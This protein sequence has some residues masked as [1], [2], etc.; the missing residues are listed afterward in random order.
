MNRFILLLLFFSFT[1]FA[2]AKEPAIDA[3]LKDT[4]IIVTAE[5]ASKEDLPPIGI[6]SQ[7]GSLAEY[8]IRFRINKI[9]KSDAALRPGDFIST[10]LSLFT[11]DDFQ[12]VVGKPL[13]L[14]LRKCSSAVDRFENTSR[15]FG[16]MNHNAIRESSLDWSI[17]EAAS[18]GKP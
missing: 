14:F 1:R 11:H 8:E 18:R 2:S 12:P 6:L 16:A 4:P 5:I 10:R 3:L 17:Q 13:I 9:L 15:W 7:G